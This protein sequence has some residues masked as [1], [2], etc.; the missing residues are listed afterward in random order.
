VS[1]L[2]SETRVQLAAENVPV[3]APER[4][5][6]TEPEGSDLEPESVSAT[7]AVQVEP[8]LIAL[9]VSQLTLV[10]V[11]RSFTVRAKSSLDVS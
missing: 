9:G 3:P 10:E 7:V 11:E 4:E 1:G 8:W 2:P 6:S 5:K